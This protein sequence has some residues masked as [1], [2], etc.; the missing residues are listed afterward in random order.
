MLKSTAW[1]WV[2]AEMVRVLFGSHTTMSAS[3]PTEIQP[4]NNN[5]KNLIYT[6]ML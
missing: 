1:W 3:E 4:C 2:L 6:D 5:K